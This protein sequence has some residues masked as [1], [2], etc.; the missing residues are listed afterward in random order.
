[1]EYRRT[2]RKLR[3]S[4]QDIVREVVPVKM[5]KVAESQRSVSLPPTL[6]YLPKVI[7]TVPTRNVERIMMDKKPVEA[8]YMC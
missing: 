2:N 4:R 5:M 1:M 6:E 7:K 8:C 3:T